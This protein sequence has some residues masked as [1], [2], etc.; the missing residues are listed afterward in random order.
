MGKKISGRILHY[1]SSQTLPGSA[2]LMA[3]YNTAL[4]LEADHDA[5][6]QQR[7]TMRLRLRRLADAM[8]GPINATGVQGWREDLLEAIAH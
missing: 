8:M 5:V 2:T 6:R 3:W 4:K 7:D 1:C